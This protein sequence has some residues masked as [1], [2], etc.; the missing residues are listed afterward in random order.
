MAEENDTTEL[1]AAQEQEQELQRAAEQDAAADR[2]D[3][4]DG[5]DKLGE[6][7]QRALESIKEQR[8]AAR[9]ERD[10]ARKEAEAFKQRLKEFEDKDKSEAQRLQEA[11]AEHQSRATKA[12]TA[13]RRRELAEELAPDH[14]TPAQIRAVAKRLSGETD[15][16]LEADARELFDLI[17]PERSPAKVTGKPAERLRPGGSDPEEPVEETDP[18]KLAALIRRS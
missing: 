2:E 12:E 15:E 8:K 5:A 1:T 14:A 4:P 3:T 16:E 13:L 7:G 9:A 6:A 11:L 10:A 18:R 17:A